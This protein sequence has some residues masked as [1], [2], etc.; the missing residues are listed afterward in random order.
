MLDLGVR[1]SYLAAPSE[2]LVLDCLETKYYFKEPLFSRGCTPCAFIKALAQG[3]ESVL[4]NDFIMTWLFKTHLAVES[5]QD[6][7]G[8]WGY[9]DWTLIPSK[10]GIYVY[11][12][13]VYTF[14]FIFKNL[15]F[16]PFF[17]IMCS[18]KLI[19]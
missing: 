16:G 2:R 7:A 5:G 15:F 9:A 3:D 6:G 19:L 8:L 14:Y 17:Y 1:I 18:V 10:F 13:S 11:Y 12:R 4:T